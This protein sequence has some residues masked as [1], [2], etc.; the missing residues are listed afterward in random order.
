[1]VTERKILTD[2]DEICFNEKWFNIG[3]DPRQLPWFNEEEIKLLTNNF[4]VLLFIAMSDETSPTYTILDN[5]TDGL[6]NRIKN[7]KEK[8][9]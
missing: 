4:L 7:E 5:L 8:N 3:N 2:T 9:I 6:I 1:M